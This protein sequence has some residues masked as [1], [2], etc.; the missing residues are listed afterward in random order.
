MLNGIQPLDLFLSK[1]TA[2]YRRACLG[3]KSCFALGYISSIHWVIPLAPF[4]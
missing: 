1:L 2:V 3:N 4:A